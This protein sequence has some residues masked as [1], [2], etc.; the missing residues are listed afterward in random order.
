MAQ[1]NSRIHSGQ[2]MGECP[3]VKEALVG[4]EGAIHLVA[5]DHIGGYAVR[6]GFYDIYGATA[7]PGGVNFTIH[8]HHAT[9]WNCFY[10]GGQRI[11]PM[12]S[13]HSHPITGLGM[14]IP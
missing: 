14:C 9:G 11:S 6:P 12:L 4:A 7:I 5:M 2:E 10:S 3:Q 13:C 8:S 1:E